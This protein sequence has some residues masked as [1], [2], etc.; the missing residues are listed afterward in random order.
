MPLKN[1]EELERIR[2]SCKALVRKR[3]AAS[4]GVAL[5]PLPGVDVL[6][7]VAMLMRLIPA[8][9]RQFG[10]TPEQIELLDAPHKA[11]VYTMIKRVGA[12]LVG[13]VITRQLLL[14]ALRKV[15]GNM[16][17][18]QVAKYV[19]FAGQALAATLSFSA[20]WY[21][22]NAHVDECFEVARSVIDENA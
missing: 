21:V 3:A 12:G 4:G 22:G 5:I 16:A 13:S 9:N 8:I 18:K 2:A 10:L 6:A 14:V 20:M 7:D 19:P 11:L 15:G 1:I 17:A